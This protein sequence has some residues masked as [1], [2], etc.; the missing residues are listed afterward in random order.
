MKESLLIRLS[1]DPKA[2]VDWIVWS[3]G[4]S[5]VIASGQLS[6]R[7]QLSELVTY[8]T[9]RR[10]WVLLSAEDVAFHSMEISKAMRP[11][12][13]KALAFCFEEELAQPVELVHVHLLAL[14]ENVVHV[15]AIEHAWMAEWRA[16]CEEAGLSILGCGIDALCLPLLDSGI[17]GIEMHQGWLM[18]ESLY[19]GA[20]VGKAWLPLWVD[21]Q[22][23]DIEI[24]HYSEAPE[25]AS[26]QWIAESAEL[27]MA[28]LA[29]G[30]D[31][32]CNLL[33]GIYHQQ[34]D[35]QKHWRAYRKVAIAA[36]VCALIG[37]A[38][39]GWQVK[40]TEQLA[41][42]YRAESERIFR[43]V[44]PQY[45]SIPTQTYLKRQM[46]DELV[47]LGTT[48]PN[49][50]LLQWLTQLSP[51]VRGFE[52]VTYKQLRFDAPRAELRLETQ[53]KSFEQ[54]EQLRTR[55]A[56]QFVVQQGQV[57]RQAD[58][59]TGTLVLKEKNG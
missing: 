51:I 13:K 46:Q 11:Q 47:K 58:S 27:P 20:C 42:A 22:A 14:Q 23:D 43:S 1:R 26:E 50:G 52:G 45:K 33:S 3:A 5:A 59:V 6:D 36:G 37:G 17:A 2:P 44:L 28:L 53:A 40:Q 49:H 41:L 12:L 24:H 7:S 34:S 18:R 38:H 55:L 16:A 54:F 8:Q 30:V 15:A 35:W 4:Q 39:F 31:F 56:Q 29:S 48:E 32:K 57:S 25:G 10:V 9:D 21:A 19:S